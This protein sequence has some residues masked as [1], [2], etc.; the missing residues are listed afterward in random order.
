MQLEL[1]GPPPDPEPSPAP[2]PKA[3]A[4][5]PESGHAYRALRAELERR[6]GMRVELIVTNNSSTIMSVKHA[7]GGELARL[8]VHRMFVD[9]PERVVGALA[10]WLT[11][12]KNTRAADILNAYIR[13][14][15]HRIQKRPARAQRLR[16]QGQRFDL[17]AL[18]REVNVAHFEGKVTA[19]ITW[20]RYPAP[21]R[22]RSITF[23][24]YSQQEHLIR[25]NPLLDLAF[26]PAYFI[27]FIV[28]HEML[29]A[30]LGI[31]ES[32]DGR[33]RIHT[34]EF[35]RIEKAHPDYARVI[36]WQEANLKRFL[37]AGFI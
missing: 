4:P 11:L 21:Q 5:P 18:F 8:R 33:R 3:A 25:I 13:D 9:A 14:Q 37:R 6:S 16:T 20:G 34:P 29:H 10:Q 28:F 26:V 30:H 31:D 22:R 12:R 2:A 19:R 1:F 7:R 15:Q 36:A 23:G 27:R 32:P 35:R 24:S 17:A